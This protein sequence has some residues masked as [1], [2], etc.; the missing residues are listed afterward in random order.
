M[1]RPSGAKWITDAALL[2]VDALVPS[3]C[4]RRP[5]RALD[6]SRT[7]RAYQPLAADVLL[8]TALLLDTPQRYE[9]IE[10]TLEFNGGLVLLVAVLVMALSRGEMGQR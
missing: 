6:S 3:W 1:Q 5:R 2:T 7:D 4:R 8:A 9:L 10:E